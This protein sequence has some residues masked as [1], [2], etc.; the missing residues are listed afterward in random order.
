M[1]ALPEQK[2]VIN[3]LTGD[4]KKSYLYDSYFF[5]EWP[6]S[7]ANYWI[8]QYMYNYWMRQF[9]FSRGNEMKGI[10]VLSL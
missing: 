1:N 10:P 7:H 2:E 5:T 8:G 9:G 3:W 6:E 4:I